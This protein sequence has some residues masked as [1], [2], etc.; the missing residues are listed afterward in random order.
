MDNTVIEYKTVAWEIL[1]DS[2]KAKCQ[3]AA[4]N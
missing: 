1:N 4:H 2:Q 3:K